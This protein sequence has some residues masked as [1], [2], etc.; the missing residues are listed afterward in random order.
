MGDDLVARADAE[1]HQRQPDGVGAVAGAD[2]V[3]HTVKGGQLLLELLEHRPLHVL[4]A[5]EHALH[6]G[7]D[8]RL[9]VPVLPDVP[10]ETDLHHHLH[11]QPAPLCRV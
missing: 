7:V 10:V 5:F 3:G 11:G 1:R 6:V 8:L 2:R 9:D 4:A